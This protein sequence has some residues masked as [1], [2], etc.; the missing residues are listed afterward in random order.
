MV[1][2]QIQL[3]SKTF[4]IRPN[5]A[6]TLYDQTQVRSN[7]LPIRP[8]CA[9][10]VYDQTQ[11][12]WITPRI[13]LFRPNWPLTRPTPDHGSDCSALKLPSRPGYLFL[14]RIVC[15]FQLQNNGEY[16]ETVDMGGRHCIKRVTNLWVMLISD[17]AIWTGH[18]TIARGSEGTHATITCKNFAKYVTMWNLKRLQ[19]DNFYR[20]LFSH[21]GLVQYAKKW[22]VMT[23]EK[24]FSFCCT[25]LKIT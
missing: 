13:R 23:I 1:P 20:K 14:S 22:E 9:R 6:R 25:V 12:R 11:V 15:A 4:L 19:F 8:N 18:K 24:S 10:T 2:D 21:N 5:C 3:L 17:L 7:A 16:S